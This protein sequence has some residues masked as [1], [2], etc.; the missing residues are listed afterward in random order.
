MKFKKKIGVGFVFFKW[1]FEKKLVGL[2]DGKQNNLLGRPNM[3][4][5]NTEKPALSS[6]TYKCQ[7]AVRSTAS[8][9]GGGGEWLGDSH[10]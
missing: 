4:T 9:R 10:T 3:I 2:D 8:R 5:T 1:Y 7:L 6:T